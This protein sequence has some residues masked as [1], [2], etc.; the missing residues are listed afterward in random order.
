MI[1]ALRSGAFVTTE[2]M[3]FVSLAL[4]ASYVLAFAWL[5]LT[6][7]GVNDAQG[8]PLGTDFSNVYAAG[9]YVLEGRPQ[10]PFDPALQYAREQALF[11]AGTPFYGWHYPPFFLLIAAALA[12][13]PYVPAL[14][15][16]QA[17]TLAL[18]LAVIRMTLRDCLPLPARHGSAWLWLLQALAFP[19]VFVNLGHGHNGFLTAALIGGGLVMLERHPRRA[20]FLFGLLVYKP[21]FGLLL[22][23]ALV[24]SSRWQAVVAAAVTVAALV[25]ATLLAFDPSTWVAFFASADFTRTVVLEAGNTGWPKIVSVF[26]LVRMWG[27]SIAFAYGVQAATTLTLAAVLVWLWRLPVDYA[28]K[29]AAL[30]VALV[31]ATPYSLDYDMT[32]LAPALAFLG[33]HGLARG[34]APYEKT[35]LAALWLAP[36][37][38]RVVAA[39]TWVPV[40]VPAMA[41]VLGLVLRRA[42]AQAD[43]RADIHA[44]IR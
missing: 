40:A 20:G 29:A 22:P 25:L 31:L 17:A 2:R 23:L 13:M 30:N 32:A 10:A 43:C 7:H 35:A 19:A 5:A 3:R 11:G 42:A 1:E 34:F 38:A 44:D 12:L 18:Y 4:L 14:L 21:Q 9:T 36:L 39:A 26:A 6:A 8:R 16:W 24:A 33:A 41:A 15:L 37:L 28:F 27:G